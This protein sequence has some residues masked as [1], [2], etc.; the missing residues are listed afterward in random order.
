MQSLKSIHLLTNTAMTEW[1]SCVDIGV[2]HE[3][4]TPLDPR[5]MSD[6][7]AVVVRVKDVLDELCDENRRLSDEMS[8]AVKCMDLLHRLRQTLKK[9]NNDCKCLHTLDHKLAF[10][11][12]E[13]QY[14]CLRM[15]WQRSVRGSDVRRS[16]TPTARSRPH[17][18]T[19]KVMRSTGRK[20]GEDRAKKL[21]RIA[22]ESQII[23]QIDSKKS[24]IGDKCGNSWTK[25]TVNYKS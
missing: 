11:R 20:S 2:K 6:T 13:T 3:T 1:M 19:T 18:M 23:R 25:R 8:S 9:F 5:V 10:N 7:N 12:L 4:I 14:K 21:K 17:A 15:D 16:H 24:R 22:I